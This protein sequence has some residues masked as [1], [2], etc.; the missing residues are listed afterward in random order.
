MSMAHFI[1]AKQADENEKNA[2]FR[3]PVQQEREANYVHDDTYP[4]AVIFGPKELGVF[5]KTHSIVSP[6]HLPNF[7][8][9]R[10][11]HTR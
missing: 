9:L 3:Q 2:F 7:A 8:E 5:K 6:L 10:P 11:R 1:E 4:T